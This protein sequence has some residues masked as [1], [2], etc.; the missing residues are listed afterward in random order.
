M[1]PALVRSWLE[2]SAPITF[3]RSSGPG[4]QN[5]NK[6]S[7]KATIAVPVRRIEGI[8]ESE[9]ALLRHRLASR[10]SEGEVL[11]IQV[12]DT[13]SQLQNRELAIDRALTAIAKGVHRARPRKPTRPSKSAKERRL[14]SKKADAR[15]K[16][17]RSAGSL[18]D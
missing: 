8:S 3:S 7:T 2:R 9:R 14:A 12:Q 6:T 10:L 4:G 17:G 1:D 13:R 18:E 11:V 15:T 5:V 16:R